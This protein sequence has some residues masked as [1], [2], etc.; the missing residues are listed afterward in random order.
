MQILFH[1]SKNVVLITQ[2]VVINLQV[3]IGRVDRSSI[4]P[5]FLG[6]DDANKLRP[7]ENNCGWASS[8]RGSRCMRAGHKEG[9]VWLLD[10]LREARED[11]QDDEAN[12]A[13]PL[14][15]LTEPSVAAMEDHNFLNFMAKMGLA[16]P[17]NEQVSL[18]HFLFYFLN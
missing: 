18:I 9:L 16:P 6:R 11:R 10:C 4:R 7:V 14:L 17:S 2:V 8:M 3:E 5:P 13:I 12:E 1:L 15:P